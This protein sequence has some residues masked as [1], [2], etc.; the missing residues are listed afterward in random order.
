[1]NYIFFPIKDAQAY[2][3]RKGILFMEVSAKTGMS[4]DSLLSKIGK[5]VLND[6]R[7][8]SHDIYHTD[9]SF[10]LKRH[11]VR[12]TFK[13]TV[14]TVRDIGLELIGLAGCTIR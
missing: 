6:R 2:A 9:I 7:A 5:C 3:E 10:F 1:M 12:S 13:F 4:V 14:F 8:S 11:F